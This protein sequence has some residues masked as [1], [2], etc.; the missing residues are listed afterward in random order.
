MGESQDELSGLFPSDLCGLE[1]KPST[2]VGLCDRVIL[3]F[4]GF[5]AASLQTTSRVWRE[6][7]LWRGWNSLKLRRSCS[8]FIIHHTDFIITLVF[9]FQPLYKILLPILSCQK[10][11]YSPTL[12]GGRM[13]NK[14][15]PWRIMWIYSSATFKR[16]LFDI[17]PKCQMS[18]RPWMH[19]QKVAVWVFFFFACG[20][21]TS[22]TNSWISIKIGAAI[23]GS[24]RMNLSDFGDAVTF[25][26]AP[27][28]GWQSRGLSVNRDQ[29]CF[30]QER[31]LFTT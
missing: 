2:G 28:W 1:S 30:N 14:H 13:I 5:D 4:C 25:P 15:K 8:R 19:R 17:W 22:P 29:P 3:V 18:E 11:S 23:L 12:P 7:R 26:L 16:S 24:Q 27:P 21:T 10:Q 20:K 31:K 9:G 6:L